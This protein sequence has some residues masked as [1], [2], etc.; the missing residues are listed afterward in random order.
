VVYHQLGEPEEARRYLQRVRDDYA[1]SSAAR[2]AVGYLQR[3]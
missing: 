3:I 1:G 2:L